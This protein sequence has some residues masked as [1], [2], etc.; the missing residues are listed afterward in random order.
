L[1]D[2]V[3]NTTQ[4]QLEDLLYPLQ[5]VRTNQGHDPNGDRAGTQL[6]YGQQVQKMEG[7]PGRYALMASVRTDNAASKNAPYTFAVEAYAVFNVTGA[8][9]EAAEQQALLANGFPLLM[10]AIREHLA[11]LTVRAPWGRFLI[12]T[13]PLQPPTQINYI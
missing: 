9:D 2:P 5:E 4:L 11:Q 13:I 6:Q 1:E 10:G 3:E 7:Q 12:N 8:A